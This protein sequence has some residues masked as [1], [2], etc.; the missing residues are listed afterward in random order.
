MSDS[1][2]K[3]AQKILNK[4]CEEHGVEKFGIEDEVGL[5][6]WRKLVQAMCG[7]DISSR[8]KPG[9]K[10]YSEE[11]I[12][13][14]GARIDIYRDFVRFDNERLEKEGVLEQIGETLQRKV[15]FYVVAEELKMEAGEEYTDGQ[16]RGIYDDYRKL[17]KEE[18]KD[19][20][21]DPWDPDEVFKGVK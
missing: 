10:A 15:A 9:R 5:V 12:L 20:E 18:I 7:I 8:E 17:R 21:N 16:I 11:F 2:V 3:A 19:L 6:C 13:N 1:K 14:V 4:L